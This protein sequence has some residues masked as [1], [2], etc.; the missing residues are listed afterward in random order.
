MKNDSMTKGEF[1]ERLRP[2]LFEAKR[3]QRLYRDREGED[4]TTPD[5]G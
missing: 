1:E 2:T 4:E 3:Q 5:R